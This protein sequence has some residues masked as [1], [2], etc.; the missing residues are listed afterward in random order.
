MQRYIVKPAT[1]R[2]LRRQRRWQVMD[3]Q[4]HVSILFCATKAE[5]ER[6][7]RWR[8]M[9]PAEQDQHQLA[10]YISEGLGE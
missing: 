6:E 2:H 7:A 5:A 1:S 9:T 4:R 3:T 8:N 10:A